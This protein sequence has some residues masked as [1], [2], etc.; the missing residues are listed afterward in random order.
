[1]SRAL[2]A[3][4][5]AAARAL[6]LAAALIC[7][8]GAAHARDAL[9]L[10]TWNLE[11]LMTAETFDR[12]A[13]SCRTEYGGGEGREIPCDIVEPAQR[14]RRRDP[15]DFA[16]LRDYARWLDADVIALQEVDGAD[17]ARLVFPDHEFCFTGREHVQN[18]GFAVRRGIAFRCADYTPLAL[19]PGGTRWGAD[20]TLHPGSGRE[21]RL[22]SVH[23][24][25]GCAGQPLTNPKE[26]CRRLAEQVPVLERWIDA[27]AREGVL[28]AVLGDFNR[29]LTRERH[30]ARDRHG[31][32]VAM[33]PELDDGQPPEADLTNVTQGQ[34]YRKC[35]LGE[36]YEAFID[37]ILVSRSL[38]ELIVPGSFEQLVY[39][40]EEA[41]RAKLSDHCP[42]A[43]TVRLSAQLISPLPAPPSSPSRP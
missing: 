26:D 5:P 8:A 19:E 21:L 2:L 36:R 13:R 32:L 27:R 31:R 22:L 37:H 3:H 9:K 15:Q 17:A 18:V 14:S 38:A 10:A 6:L 25:S 30:S 7:A 20:L 28:F 12:L 11:W 40:R 33:W 34:P 41:G 23:L 35:R 4:A 24:K 39:D 16:K 42:I 29:R 43:V 1:V